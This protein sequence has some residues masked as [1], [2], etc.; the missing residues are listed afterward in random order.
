[1]H[2]YVYVYINALKC[3]LGTYHISSSIS[4]HGSFFNRPEDC[5]R[6]FQSRALYKFRL[7]YHS[8]IFDPSIYEN[9]PSSR[10]LPSS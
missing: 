1:M 2:V 7:D 4:P 8:S 10:L 3:D 9:N 6:G 5:N